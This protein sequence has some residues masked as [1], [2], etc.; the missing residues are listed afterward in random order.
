[1]G[2]QDL[3]EFINR[4]EQEGE[5]QRIKAQV[6]WNLEL[7]NIMRKVAAIK[8]PAVLF[9]NVKDSQ[10]RFFSGGCY[11]YKKLGLAVGSEPTLRAILHKCFKAINNP[12]TPV[13]VEKGACQ[14]NVDTGD[15][16]DLGK[17]PAPRWHHLD[18]GRF[19]GTM[20]TIV[21]KDPDTGVRNYAVYRHQVEGKNKIGLDILGQHGGMHLQKYLALKKPMPFATAI[22]VQ[23]ECVI[24]AAIKAPAGQDELGI[25][26]GIGGE[27]IKLVK[28]QTCDLEVPANAE[29]VLE[30]EILPDDTTWEMEGPFGE[31][32]GFF[33]T[34]NK[35]KRPTGFLKAVTYRDNPIENGC[36]PGIPPNEASTMR[37]IGQ[38]IGNWQTLLKSGIPGIKDVYVTEMSCG[39]KVIISMDRQYYLG[40][41]RQL[42]FSAFHSLYIP[43]WVIV[44]D[45][46]ID[47]YDERQVDWAISVRVQPHRDI[48]ITDDRVRANYIDP[49]IHP[50]C[51]KT[52]MTARTSKIG[53]DATMRFK[54][55]EF[56]PFV[57]PNPEEMKFIDSRW[58]E[59]GFN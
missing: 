1:M 41:A 46:D 9:E 50:D 15:N 40:N 14:E 52:Q 23:P 44:V 6:D 5:L 26:G 36:A 24:A 32:P 54:D 58:K 17:F 47:I 38:T 42:I 12:V 43:K 4:L 33:G 29:I 59:Y 53:I 13:V 39:F 25:A 19:I 56:P 51:K 55:F 11:G 34:L 28:C 2:Y 35:I 21:T 10:F 20:G 22:G 45:D 18:G 57:K 48:I 31:F 16:I 37:E 49:S 8:G 3:R 30:G 7:G 27:P